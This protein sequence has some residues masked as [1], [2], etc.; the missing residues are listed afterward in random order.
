MSD[1]WSFRIL[2]PPDQLR[3]GHVRRLVADLVG[4]GYLAP[5]DGASVWCMSADGSGAVAFDSLDAAASWL[6]AGEGLLPLRRADLDL[7]LSVHRADGILAT[8]MH[9]LPDDPIFHVVALTL[10]KSVFPKVSWAAIEEAL[11]TSLRA[12]PFS[13]AY[14]ISDATAES[15]ADYECVHRR[16]A[17]GRLPPFLPWISAVPEQ[18][19]ALSAAIDQAASLVGRSVARCDGLRLLTLSDTPL[20]GPEHAVLQASSRWREATHDGGC[21]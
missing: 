2:C 10:A 19:R 7:D 17:A 20:D 18:H 6:D 5:G 13:F 16:V 3:A 14:G 12:L 21:A 15:V 1:W 9:H 4:L 11:F 8:E